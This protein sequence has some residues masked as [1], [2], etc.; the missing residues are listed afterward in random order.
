MSLRDSLIVG[1]L[2]MVVLLQ[3]YLV[4]FGAAP[5][6]VAVPPRAAKA[7]PK[8]S[9]SQ[10]T[11]PAP[12]SP[13]AVAS[14][15]PSA[16][17]QRSGVL[18]MR[19]YLAGVAALE[20]SNDLQLTSEQAAALLPIL[21]DYAQGYETIP[22]VQKAVVDALSPAQRAYLQRTVPRRPPKA[23]P[24]RTAEAIVIDASQGLLE[25]IADR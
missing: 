12:P 20:S 15:R 13:L 19:E 3:S 25:R 4:L 16:T 23:D 21:R 5:R 2:L 6:S 10:E 18:H 11:S 17:P 7:P 9:P 1:L 24:R 8:P 22:Q 14:E